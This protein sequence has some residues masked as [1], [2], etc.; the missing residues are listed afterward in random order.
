MEGD[1]GDAVGSVVEVTRLDC[2]L[3]V[4]LV[5]VRMNVC[6]NYGSTAQIL[7]KLGLARRE[8]ADT[9]I[10]NGSGCAP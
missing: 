7:A 4:T 3:K 5:P 6:Y 1:G 2:S 10:I 8:T 9:A